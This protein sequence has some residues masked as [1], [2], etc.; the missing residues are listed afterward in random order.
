LNLSQKKNLTDLI[1]AFLSNI[2]FTMWNIV[3]SLLGDSVFNKFKQSIRRGTE[4]LERIIL[5]LLTIF[6]LATDRVPSQ[7]EVGECRLALS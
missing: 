4:E 5:N 6:S 1:T 7:K 3:T 2:S